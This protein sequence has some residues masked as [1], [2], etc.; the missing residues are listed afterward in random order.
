MVDQRNSLL[1]SPIL[2]IS[3]M[4]FAHCQDLEHSQVKSLVVKSTLIY[5]I[6]TMEIAQTLRKVECQLMI[7][8]LMID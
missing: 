2:W 1:L 3:L 6:R 8:W 7:D 5:L 4:L